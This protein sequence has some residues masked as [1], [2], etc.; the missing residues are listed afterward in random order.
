MTELIKWIKKF[1]SIIK[2]HGVTIIKIINFIRGGR[3]AFKP[4]VPVVEIAIIKFGV[5]MQVA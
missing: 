2:N 4:V 5:F 1:Q 3:P